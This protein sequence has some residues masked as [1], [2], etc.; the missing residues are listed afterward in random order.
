MRFLADECCNTKVV[1]TLRAEGYDVV[2]MRE[3]SPRADDN[4]VLRLASVQ[5]LNEVGA[6]VDVYRDDLADMM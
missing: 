3:L 6:I 5:E 2:S 4:E 1:E